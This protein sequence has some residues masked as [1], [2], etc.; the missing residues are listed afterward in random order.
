MMNLCV[1]LQTKVKKFERK[2][3]VISLIFQKYSKIIQHLARKVTHQT[4]KRTA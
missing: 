3:Q 4:K 2:V 1:E